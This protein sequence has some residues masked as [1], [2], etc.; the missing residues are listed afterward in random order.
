MTYERRKESTKTANRKK[1]Y[2]ND[3][4][5]CSDLM[6]GSDSE[7]KNSPQLSGEVWNLQRNQRRYTQIE[8]VESLVS[9]KIKI[10]GESKSDAMEFSVRVEE[11]AGAFEYEH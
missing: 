3:S 5:S 8:V 10:S 1:K 4:E 6:S 9:R 2:D 7:D 11:C